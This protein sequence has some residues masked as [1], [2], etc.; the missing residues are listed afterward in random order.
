MRVGGWAV[1][2]TA[3]REERKEEGE[4]EE[5]TSRYIRLRNEAQ[6]VCD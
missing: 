2:A 3:V 6:D 5:N 1:S 4:T